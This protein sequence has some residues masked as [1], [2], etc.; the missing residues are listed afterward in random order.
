MCPGQSDPVLLGALGLWALALAIDDIRHRRVL[1][2][3]LLPVAVFALAARTWGGWPGCN[4]SLTDGLM[5]AGLGLLLWLPG[6]VMKHVGAGD[7]KCAMVMGLVLG[8]SRALEANLLGAIAL[9]LIALPVM[10]MGMGRVRIPAVPALAC[11]FVAELA[12]GPWLLGK[13]PF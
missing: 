5:G 3:M 11:G 13:L 2:W 1:N 10:W 7:V 9:G 12:G 4:P 6:Y 8:A